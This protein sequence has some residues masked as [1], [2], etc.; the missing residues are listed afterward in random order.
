MLRGLFVFFSSDSHVLSGSLGD[1]GWLAFVNTN[2]RH[3]E[4]GKFLKAE[5]GGLRWPHQPQAEIHLS[6]QRGWRQDRPSK[7]TGQFLGPG[8]PFPKY[9]CQSLLILS[10]VPSN[11]RI[12]PVGLLLPDAQVQSPGT[13]VGFALETSNTTRMCEHKLHQLVLSTYF[14]KQT[15][16]Q[17]AQ[18]SHR[19]I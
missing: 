7:N 14:H 18:N 12:L 6:T 9:Q 4:K 19:A 17:A 8:P 5:C 10:R 2:C 1:E 16:H 15:K 3:L 13:K 11:S